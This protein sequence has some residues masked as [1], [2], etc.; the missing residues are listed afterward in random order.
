MQR[1]KNSRAKIFAPSP[2]RSPGHMLRQGC[3]DLLPGLLDVEELCTCLCPSSCLVVRLVFWCC[4][5]VSPSTGHIMGLIETANSNILPSGLLACAFS[6]RSF[7]FC[8]SFFLSFFLSFFCFFSF[9]L[10]P[11]FWLFLVFF[12]GRTYVC[13]SDILPVLFLCKRQEMAY[14]SSL[15]P[16]PRVLVPR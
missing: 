8:F 5:S 1:T 6:A 13:T 16:S 2:A 9:I 12:F 14:H 3:A 11:S 10:F 4:R 7:L 15:A